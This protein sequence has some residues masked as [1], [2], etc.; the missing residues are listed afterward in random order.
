M[1]K[2]FLSKEYIAS[3]QKKESILV[4]D[5]GEKIVT[6]SSYSWNHH[7]LQIAQQQLFHWITEKVRDLNETQFFFFVLKKKCLLRITLRSSS[8]NYVHA[9]I[10]PLSTT[11]RQL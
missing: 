11:W 4:A 9:E 1:I 8:E 10:Q 6:Q 2:V 5:I 3:L 7:K